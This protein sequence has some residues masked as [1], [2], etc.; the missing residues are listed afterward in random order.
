MTD[1]YLDEG[2]SVHLAPHL[3]LNGHSTRTTQQEGRRGGYDA[4]QLLHAA[5]NGWALVTHNRGHFVVLHEGWALWTRAWGI[6]ILHAGILIVPQ[7]GG[8]I[9]EDVLI[10]E[11]TGFLNHR[12]PMTNECREWI[13]GRNAWWRHPLRGGIPP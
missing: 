4:A 7:V 13:P 11:I 10:M 1:L 3:T 8:D 6:D 5:R 2:V 9:T 12:P